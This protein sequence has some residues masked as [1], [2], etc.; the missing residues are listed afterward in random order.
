M[1]KQ[2]CVRKRRM[3]D[4]DFVLSVR[5][6]VNDNFFDN[7]KNILGIIHCID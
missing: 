1:K 7:S 3:I 5:V 4:N 2:K 6:R